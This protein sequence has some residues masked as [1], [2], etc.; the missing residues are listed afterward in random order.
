MI[1]V[2]INTQQ[3]QS[4]QAATEGFSQRRMN[5]VIA[6]ALT[7]TAVK[8]REAIKQELVRSVDRPTAYT[9]RGIFMKPANA[10]N[11]QARIWYN[12]EFK[13]MNVPQAR[14][15]YPQIHGGKRVQKRFEKA[16]EAKG[17]MPKGYMAV[18]TSNAPRDAHGNVSRGV[19]AQMVSQIGTELMSGYNSTISSNKAKKRRAIGRAGG[20][21]VAVPT[22]RGKLKPGVYLAVA[23]NFGRK[24]GLGRTGNLVP[25]FYYKPGV[26][27][28]ARFRFYETAQQSIARTIDGDL[29]TAFNESLARLRAKGG[30]A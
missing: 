4:I 27:Y 28:R 24:W 17:A 12:D 19:I 10:Q 14:Y 13:G 9:Q 6:T 29:Q 18:P 16:L 8:A 23:R 15:L 22:Q 21:Y 7:R 1:T 11:L 25:M 3:L 5:A 26:N 2:K 20:Q 30:Q